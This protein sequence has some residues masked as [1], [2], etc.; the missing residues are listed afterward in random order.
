MNAGGCPVPSRAGSFA[1][2]P[3]RWLSL[4]VRWISLHI[5]VP[6]G[7]VSRLLLH[8]RSWGPLS[9]CMTVQWWSQVPSQSTQHARTLCNSTPSGNLGTSQCRMSHLTRPRFCLTTPPSIHAS[10]HKPIRSKI[11]Q[12]GSKLRGHHYLWNP[13]PWLRSRRLAALLS[14]GATL[15]RLSGRSHGDP[16]ACLWWSL[17]PSA[18]DWV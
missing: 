10:M 11:F 3:A 1:S 5:L 9:S 16:S 18:S 6:D 8:S 4:G 15:P 12:K 7:L 2:V 17:L 13:G 14:S